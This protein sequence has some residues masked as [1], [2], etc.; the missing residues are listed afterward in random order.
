MR[1]DGATDGARGQASVEVVA[2]IPIVMLCGLLGLQGLV[3]G[4]NFVAAGHAAHA[5]ALAGQLG[6]DPLRAARRATPGWPRGSM[7]VHNDDGLVAVE[8]R[9]RSLVPG[10]S[11]L[12]VARA[13]ARYAR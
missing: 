2:L 5:G 1:T 11:G 7:S 12:L 13:E 3:A 6:R 4:A 9:P 8:L 10:L